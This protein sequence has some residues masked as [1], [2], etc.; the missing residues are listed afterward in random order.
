MALSVGDVVTHLKEL[1][2]LARAAEW[3]NVGLLLGDL[4]TDVKRVMTCLTLTPDVAK[5]A[6]ERRAELIV[7]HHPILFRPAK[8]LTTNTSE[9]RMILGLVRAGASV[10][11]A[12]T[13]YDNAPGGLNDL[14]ATNLGLQ[15]VAPLKPFVDD[16]KAG[17]GR[18]GILSKKIPFG[19]FA[20]LAKQVLGAAH[21]DCVGDANRT[22]GK[23]AIVCGAGGE[24]LKDA[25]KARAEVF[26]TG[27]LRFHD[28]LMAEAA[29]VSL[30]LP[31]H[32][33]S[34]RIGMEALA[35]RLKS[36]F[37]GLDV[38]ASEHERDPIHKVGD[39]WKK[40][41]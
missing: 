8:T 26:L 25:M 18:I 17:E 15:S 2:P 40:R 29:G 20:R 21:V 37:S 22:I 23:V 38:W 11:S 19:E 5:E 9:G 30:C 4:Q 34:E 14:L 33:A 1:A 36:Q 16:P 27:E 3:D 32:Y 10:Y 6:I 31:G 28:Y 13:A 41:L 39:L 24:F 7:T 35:A 12:H